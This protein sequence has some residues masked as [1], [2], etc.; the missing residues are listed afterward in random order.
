MESL[1]KIRLSKKILL[2]LLFRN[3]EMEPVHIFYKELSA[4]DNNIFTADITEKNE[5]E[6]VKLKKSLKYAVTGLS[7]NHNTGTDLV[8]MT[9]FDRQNLLSN[10]IQKLVKEKK[11][12]DL[13]LKI[14]NPETKDLITPF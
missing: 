9:N 14:S 2:L 3:K 12:P 1:N 7:I 13:D 5:V 6:N 4:H 8:T 10:A 11:D